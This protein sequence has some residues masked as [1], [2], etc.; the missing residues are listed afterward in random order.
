[1]RRLSRLLTTCLLV[2]NLC[3][4]TFEWQSFTGLGT[5]QDLDAGEG[6]VWAGTDGGVLQLDVATQAV[7]KF[8]NTEGLA[9]NQVVAVEIDRHGTVW[10]G[11]A[12]GLLNRYDPQTGR[13]DL[14]NDYRDQV[15]TDLVAFG[16]SLYVGL[17]IGVSLFTIDKREVKETYVNFGLSGGTLEKIGA[18]AVF[19]DG[20]D[21][22]VATDQGIA[23]SSLTFTNLQAPAN[24]TQ[25]TAGDGLPT[26]TVNKVVVLDGVPYAATAQGVSRLVNGVWQDVGALQ[27]NVPTLE[28]V[29][30][31]AFFPQ[32]T[33]VTFTRS[34]VFWLDPTDRWVRLGG[35][36]G[37]VTALTT[38]ETG[39]VWIGRKERGLATFDFDTR[40]WPL[41]EVNGPRSSNFISLAL[42]DR[43]RLWCAAQALSGQSGGVQMFDGERWWYFSQQDGLGNND[44]RTVAVAGDRVF[45]GSWGGG[46]SIFQDLGDRFDITVIDTAGGVLA[47][48]VTP[49][50][51]LVNDLAVDRLGNLWALN[52]QANNTQVLVAFSPE[53]D[54]VHFSS[55][56]G[57]FTPFVTVLAVDAANRIWVGTDDRGIKVLDYNNTL[58]DKSDDDFTQGLVQ[59]EGLLSNRIT[60]LASDEDGVMWIGT[61]EGLNFWFGGQ[62]S[63]QFGLIND[64]VNTI[65]V[66]PQNNKWFGT[67]NGVSVLRPDGVTYTHFTTRNSP[68]VNDTILSFAFNPE[69]GEVWI[70][71]SGGLSRLQ[72]PFTAPREDLTQLSG[73]PNPFFLDGSG[74]SF[75][76]VN[77]TRNTSVVIYD[78]AGRKI[79]S[80]PSDEIQ[81]AQVLWDGRDTQGNLVASGIYVY[82]AYTDGNLSAAGKVAVIRR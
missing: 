51:V 19:I 47:G 71:T 5:I 3:G 21:I 60:A 2:G 80:F 53:G 56:E 13:W 46:M 33:L 68:L 79:R 36:L 10:F 48:S 58:L 41:L 24:W 17:N 75:A 6:F 54:V 57:L 29:P 74:T 8:T 22:W 11:L 45:F 40:A 7:T 81:G 69:T 23:Q 72:T 55:N 50:F 67:A 44:Q 42:D 4:Q 37:D 20:L 62:V 77:L 73:F 27:T 15:I 63:V 76:I 59:S 49:A 16:D 14:V 66:D 9:A 32:K 70:G 1:M 61:E 31:N 64:F 28:I 25:Y 43:G 35:G 26:N 34:G 18:N 12:N 52:R 78:V 65:G 38:D 30:A 39:R 82:L